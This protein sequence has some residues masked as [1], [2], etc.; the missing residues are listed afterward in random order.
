MSPL[1][2]IFLIA[3]LLIEFMSGSA[4]AGT[5][6]VTSADYG[7]LPP[8][9]QQDLVKQLQGKNILSNNDSIKYTGPAASEERRSIGPAIL[10]TLG[11]LACKAIAA[12]KKQE[13]LNQ[14][15]AKETNLRDQCSMA[16]ES[17]FST[18]DAVCSA[19]KLF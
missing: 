16:I 4:I 19:I 14:C 10:V 3:A 11:P 1:L 12:A 13:D 8:D 17:K 2:R 9:A 5:I 18:I 7:Q 6:E 15:A